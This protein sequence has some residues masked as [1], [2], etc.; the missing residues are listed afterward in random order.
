MEPFG[1][2]FRVRYAECDAQGIVF[3]AR[4]GDYVDLAATEFL[5]A[6]DHDYQSLVAQGLETQVVRLVLE[7]Q[8]PARFDEVLCAR[9]ACSRLGRTSYTLTTTFERWGTDEV[10]ATAECVYV[11]VTVDPY[12]PTPIPEAMR[13]VLEAG[14]PGV[15]VDQAAVLPS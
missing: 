8:A 12:A 4:Y 13:D 6:M 11:F 15:L 3:N 9:V 2:L 5:R 10:V 14:V 7:W 1:L